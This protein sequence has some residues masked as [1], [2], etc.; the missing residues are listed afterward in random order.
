MSSAVKLKSL[1][2]AAFAG[3]L[4]L[5]AA[6]AWWLLRGGGAS[7]FSGENVQQ[8]D[9]GGAY[10]TLEAVNKAESQLSQAEY[11]EALAK[12]GSPP[13]IASIVSR[14]RNAKATSQK[15]IDTRKAALEALFSLKNI[16]ARLESVL[17]AVDGDGVSPDKDPLWDWTV[18]RLADTWAERESFRKARDL[19]MLEKREEPRRLL[20]AS[21]A[22]V[23]DSPLA[24]QK[25]TEVERHAMASDLIEV[26]FETEDPAYKQELVR[27]IRGLAGDDVALVLTEGAEGVA[28]NQVGV[29]VKQQEAIRQALADPKSIV[30]DD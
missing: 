22:A 6:G 30:P 2:A 4:V 13:A 28:P 11:L 12:V 27:G 19:M 21:V 8:V 3:V 16:R 14:Y 9:R 7:F 5:G 25:L 18:D 17:S 29:L 1:L 10:G 24:Q 26:Y 15:G 23:G 20:A